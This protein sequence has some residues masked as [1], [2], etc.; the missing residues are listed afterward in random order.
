MSKHDTV[1]ISLTQNE[2]AWIEYLRLESGDADPPVTLARVP[3]VR[4]CLRRSLD[5]F[6][7]G[8]EPRQNRS[9]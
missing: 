5:G 7:T 1:T 3:A 6:Q 2:V 9:I 8:N 4:N